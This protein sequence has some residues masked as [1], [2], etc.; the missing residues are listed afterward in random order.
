EVADYHIGGRRDAGVA[1]RD[2]VADVRRGG[3][4]TG[5]GN[6][7]DPQHR[8]TRGRVAEHQGDKDRQN[9]KMARCTAKSKLLHDSPSGPGIESPTVDGPRPA[10]LLSPTPGRVQT[11]RGVGADVREL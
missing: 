6:L 1:Q 10:T 2:R 9:R 8:F 5:V 11:E 3:D 7:G 4:R